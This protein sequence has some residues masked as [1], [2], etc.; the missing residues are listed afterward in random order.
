VEPL[1][2]TQMAWEVDSHRV[3]NLPKSWKKLLGKNK[4]DVIKP[5]R[6]NTCSPDCI[7]TA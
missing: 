6:P 1:D 5:G 3:M 4:I 7:L 2:P